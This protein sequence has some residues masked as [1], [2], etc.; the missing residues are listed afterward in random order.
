MFERGARVLPFG[1]LP[2]TSILPCPQTLVTLTVLQLRNTPAPAHHLPPPRQIPAY[3]RDGRFSTPL[4]LWQSPEY[5]YNDADHAAIAVIH[6]FLHGI[7]EFYL[8][9]FAY[10]GYF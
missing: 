6:D 4:Q 10:G 7:L 8:A 5:L 2:L 9:F 3:A 1:F